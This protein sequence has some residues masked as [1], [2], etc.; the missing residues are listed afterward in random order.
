MKKLLLDATAGNRMM[1]KNK[2]PPNTVFMDKNHRSQTPPD[3]LAVWEAPPFRD[4]IFES[5]LFDP[6]HKFNRRSGFWADPEAPNYY[7]ADIRREKLVSGIY[8]GTREFLKIAKRLCF[9]W[10]DDEISLPR[11]LSLF[12][13]AWK[14]IHHRAVDKNNAHKNLIHYITFKN[15]EITS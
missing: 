9:K 14:K 8:R 1:W 7:G 13:R 12:P 11:I 15:K 5:V 6:P 10:S 3:I 2:N 4:N